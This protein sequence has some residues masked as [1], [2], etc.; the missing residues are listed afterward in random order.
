MSANAVSVLLC[1]YV[2]EQH[3]LDVSEKLM[4]NFIIQTQTR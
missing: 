4:V 2:N 3:A 1:G